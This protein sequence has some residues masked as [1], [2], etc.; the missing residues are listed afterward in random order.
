MN[1]YEKKRIE[2]AF[3]WVQK[4]LKTNYNLIFQQFKAANDKDVS[5]DTHLAVVRS[6]RA[7]E[8]PNCFIVYF[9]VNNIKSRSFAFLKQD[10]IHEVLHMI[11]WTR[12][13]IFEST[14]QHVRS[15][16]LKADLK[17]RF[18]DS[19]E[20]V[21]YLLERTFGPFVIKAWKDEG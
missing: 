3:T 8:D 5:P 10:A 16:K 15:S 17:K 19:D 1:Q 6:N 7:T 11:S 21:T 20:A 18:Y 13:E 4:K 2:K 12:R 9:D 14:V